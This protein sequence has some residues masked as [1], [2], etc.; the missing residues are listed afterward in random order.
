MR[1]TYHPRVQ[2]SPHYGNNPII[3]LDG[4]A[5]DQRATVIRQ[6]RRMETALHAIAEAQWRAPSRCEG[7]SVQD[8]VAHLVDTNGFWGAS[9]SQ[10]L[11][12]TPT[13][14][15]DGFDPK[16]TPAALV[17]AVRNATPAE[18]LARLVNSNRALFELI[19]GLD[20]TGW[21]T[22][23]EAPPG[24]LPVRLVAHHALWDGWVHERDILLPLG[25]RPDEEP[26]EVAA[27]LRY[28]A[29]VA[30][31]FAVMG[32]AAKSGTL[33]VEAAHPDLRVVVDVNEVVRVHDDPA[34]VGDL[35]L[36]GE[37]IDLL[38]ALSVRKP[39]GVRVPEE[40]RWLIAGLTDV[41]EEAPI[42]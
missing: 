29:A 39:L 17:E 15:L 33:V 11:S 23:A 37:A 3:I 20:H 42:A 14:I 13:R 10:A 16:A 12:G 40:H 19:E 1:R 26:D 4:P 18:T 9:I 36:R 22:L 6:R 31:A 34:A 7:W 8:V 30:P 35:V 2:I 5:D 41:F 38:E 25:V 32:K 21:S 24:H 27:C 28:V